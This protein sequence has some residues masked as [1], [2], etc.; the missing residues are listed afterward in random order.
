M[1]DRPQFTQTPFVSFASIFTANTAKDGTGTI[2]TVATVTNAAGARVESI[3]AMATGSVGPGMIRYYLKS[4]SATYYLWREVP[5][6]SVT[7]SNTGSCYYSLLTF[8]PP[9]V[10]PSGTIIG[11]A[12]ELA[13]AFT[14]Y[15][16]GGIY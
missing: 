6:S 4:G 13:N 16:Y 3:Q 10:L 12:P 2:T 14:V 15:V 5:V 7:A 8:S 11:A 1:A 9:M